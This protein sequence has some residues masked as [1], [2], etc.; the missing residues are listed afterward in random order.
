MKI[1]KWIQDWL[2][3]TQ[4]DN[5]LVASSVHLEHLDKHLA[6]FTNEFVKLVNANRDAVQ[7][8]RNLYQRI[9]QKFDNVMPASPEFFDEMRRQMEARMD[10]TMNAC[11]RMADEMKRARLTNVL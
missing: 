9:S 3:L 10:Q 11:D 2:G 7:E 5:Q 4:L 6:A 8:M 1:Q